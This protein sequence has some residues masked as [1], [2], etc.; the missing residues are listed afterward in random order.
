M[1]TPLTNLTNTQL[2]QYISEHRNDQ[3]ACS[4]ALNVLMSRSNP[5]NRRPFSEN[6]QELERELN[7]FLQSKQDL[8]E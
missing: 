7:A 6:L 1:T 8:A 2:K 3:D 5:A 4:T